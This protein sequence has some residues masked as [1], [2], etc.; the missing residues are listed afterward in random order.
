[1]TDRERDIARI[2]ARETAGGGSEIFLT[3][4]NALEDRVRAYT[5]RLRQKRALASASRPTSDK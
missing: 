5:Q 1:M 2:T 4:E 3:I